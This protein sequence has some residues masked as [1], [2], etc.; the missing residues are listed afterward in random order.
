MTLNTKQIV[1]LQ[2]KNL[3]LM[4]NRMAYTQ[5]QITNCTG[6]KIHFLVQQLQKTFSI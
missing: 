4:T 6:N 3:F 1:G 2:D 5:K